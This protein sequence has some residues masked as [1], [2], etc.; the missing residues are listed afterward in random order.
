MIIGFNKKRSS[1]TLKIVVVFFVGGAKLRF[2]QAFEGQ[3]R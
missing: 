3:G 2:N 1:L